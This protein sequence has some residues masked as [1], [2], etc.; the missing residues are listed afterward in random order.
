MTHPIQKV[1]RDVPDTEV[2]KCLALHRFLYD[3]DGEIWK[4]VDEF[5]SLD[6]LESTATNAARKYDFEKVKTKTPGAIQEMLETAAN[7]A[8]YGVAFAAFNIKF[9]SYAL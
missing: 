8:K 9:R 7:A 1:Y 4:F 2:Q 3:F 5:L 6:D